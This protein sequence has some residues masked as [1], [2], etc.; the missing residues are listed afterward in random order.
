MAKSKSESDYIPNEYER[1][2]DLEQRTMVSAAK[3]R[4]LER[5]GTG[6]RR[7][8]VGRSVL[9]RRADVDASLETH[10]ASEP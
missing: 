3:W 10:A 4:Q 6:P 1:L 2:V 5:E 9:F 8:K 7:Y